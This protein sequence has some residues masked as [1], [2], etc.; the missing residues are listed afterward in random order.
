MSDSK[1]NLFIGKY[2]RNLFRIHSELF[3]YPKIYIKFSLV[4]IFLYVLHPKLIALFLNF[5]LKRN[6]LN[7]K[8]IVYNAAHT[9]IYKD[10]L[11]ENK[12]NFNKLNQ[13]T[14]LAIKLS[15]YKLL[16]KSRL[17]LY[18]SKDLVKPFLKYF[19]NIDNGSI[20][21]LPHDTYPETFFLTQL[22]R[23]FNLC[24]TVCVQHG[25]PARIYM[26]LN[27]LRY[28]LFDGFNS[29]ILLSWDIYSSKL[30]KKLVE[31][32]YLPINKKLEIYSLNSCPSL[33]GLN[34]KK[35]SYS[36]SYLKKMFFSNKFSLLVIEESTN[37]IYFKRNSHFN[38]FLKDI[39]SEEFLSDFNNIVFHEKVLYKSYGKVR[40]MFFDLHTNRIEFVYSKNDLLR[41]A[42]YLIAFCGVTT[43]AYE[44]RLAGAYIIGIDC[45]NFGKDSFPEEIYNEYVDI[46][47]NNFM[48]LIKD[49]I[50]NFYLI[51]Q[52]E[53]I[54]D[55]KSHQNNS[56]FEKSF[57]DFLSNT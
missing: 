4:S 20:L 51:K 45:G 32:S 21:I 6:Q 28:S 9:K 15:T 10:I 1:I 12:I 25:T 34:K 43:L 31:N 33:H 14:I 53:D 36:D 3:E 11:Q 17:N 48:N 49:Q 57:L 46:S 55:Y 50:K 27:D 18:S 41:N 16:N 26:H 2:I 54:K 7:S 22:C 24:K 5:T 52:K 56:I 8:I 38:K 39:S 30:M 40:K 23:E 47:K 35:H 44:L 19:S 42:K 37:K 29:D 13:F